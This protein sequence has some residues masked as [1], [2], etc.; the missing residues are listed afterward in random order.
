MKKNLLANRMRSDNSGKVIDIKEKNKKKK[1]G[2]N[3]FKNETLNVEPPDQYKPKS[4]NNKT[5]NNADNKPKRKKEE[6][7]EQN[8]NDVKKP[9]LIKSRTSIN[10]P[11]ETESFDYNDFDTQ[12]ETELMM[13]QFRENKSERKK[14][15][16]ALVFRIGIIVLCVYLAFL[17]YGVIMTQYVYNENG[18][19]TPQVLSVDDLTNLEE[20]RSISAYYLR[21]RIIYEKVLNLNY[22]LALHPDESLM[23][24][25]DYN[26]ML[27][28][29]EKLTIDISA[30]KFS[31]K[32]ETIHKQLQFWVQTDM[33]LYLQNISS[34]I[35]N[36]NVEKAQAA[37]IA[38]DAVQN[39][40]SIITQNLYTIGSSTKGADNLD[41][42]NWSP[43]TYIQ[44]LDTE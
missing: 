17:I 19:V 38:K 43:I 42:Y 41:I 4:K 26:A 35:T 33:A 12:M 34:A 1:N 27:D 24:A 40:F 36:N 31:T 25:M 13:K 37:I 5:N 2:L 10:K 11:D 9:G 22:K 20:Y 7:T 29:V 23:I 39:D 16:I 28:E 3:I 14:A 30:A 32:Y 44:S 21:A 15:R 8:V 18:I 6:I